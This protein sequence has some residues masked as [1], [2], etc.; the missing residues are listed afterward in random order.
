VVRE[1]F[2]RREAPK[3]AQ[4]GKPGRK[5]RGE[6]LREIADALKAKKVAAPQDGQWHAETVLLI[7]RNAPLCGKV[8]NG[9]L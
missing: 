8:L 1:I 2:R 5:F 9:L 7:L 6:S 4:P 3:P